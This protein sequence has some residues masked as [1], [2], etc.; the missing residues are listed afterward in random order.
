MTM[1]SRGTMMMLAVLVC[2]IS[3]TGVVRADISVL[4]TF[5]EES[6][7]GVSDASGNERD[8]SE[9][10]S[11]NDLTYGETGQF[12]NA[13]LFNGN[14]SNP[15]GKFLLMTPDDG[16]PGDGDEVTIVFWAKSANWATDNAV[17][18]NYNAN[19]LRFSVGLNSSAYGLVIGVANGS[20]SGGGSPPGSS[21]KAYVKLNGAGTSGV[22]LSAN[23][24]HHFALVFSD[25]T[26][27]AIYIDGEEVVEDGDSYWYFNDVDT[28]TVG[29]RSVSTYTPFVF[30]G[31]L[32]DFAI[33]NE[34]LDESA[35]ENIMANGVPTPLFV[36]YAFDEESGPGVLDSSGN[37]RDMSETSSGN[38]LTYG[39]T[40]QFEN[41]LRFNGNDGNPGGK[42]LL[43]TP[44]AGMPGDGDEVTIVFWA[45]SANWAGDNAIICNYNANGLRFSVGLN[46]TNYGLTVGVA[47]GSASG[48]GSPPGNSGKAY[49]KL[50]GAGTSGVNLSAN[51]W[52]HFAIAFSDNAISAI[53]IDGDEVAED[54]D[55]YWY[56][57]DV[58]NFTIGGRILGTSTPFVFNGLLDDF[59]IYSKVLS[60]SEI[61]DIMAGAGGSGGTGTTV[62]ND[63]FET[64]VL[65]WEDNF[66]TFDTNRW[67]TY[68]QGDS[69][70]SVADGK[71]C[72]TLNSKTGKSNARVQ[73]LLG[74][75]T[76]YDPSVH[77]EHKYGRVVC[78]M[79]TTTLPYIWSTFYAIHQDYQPGT[80]NVTAWTELDGGEYMGDNWELPQSILYWEGELGGELH[81]SVIWR[82]LWFDSNADYHEY[83]IEWTPEHL[84]Y[85]VDG[86]ITRRETPE[87]LPAVS[88]F[89][90]PL[91]IDMSQITRDENLASSNDYPNTAYY[92]YIAYYKL[93]STE[94]LAASYDSASGIQA[95]TNYIYSCDPGDYAYYEDVDLKQF[96]KVSLEVACQS[97][98]REVL[99]R[100]GSPTGTVIATIPVPNTG[101][102]TLY[103]TSVAQLGEVSGVQDLYLTFSGGGCGNI[104]NFRFFGGV[105]DPNHYPDWQDYRD[106]LSS[107]SGLLA[108]Y[109]FEA[110]SGNTLENIATAPSNPSYFDGSIYDSSSWT[111]GRW[112]DKGALYFDGTSDSVNCGND[113]R[114]NSSTLT[115]EAWV[116]FK[117][118]STQGQG[119][120]SKASTYKGFILQLDG[121]TLR[122]YFRDASSSSWK[123]AQSTYTIRN[124]WTHIVGM[125]KSNGDIELWVDGILRGTTSMGTWDTD[126]SDL[127]I[128]LVGTTGK[129]KGFIDEVAIYNREL[130]PAEIVAHCAAGAR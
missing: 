10:S 84:S 117:N 128:G 37:L 30:N 54:G 112:T 100:T 86:H 8:M 62:T 92:D 36:H 125:R 82:D 34:A 44:D 97:D 90:F 63:L 52:H 98:D 116:L 124:A 57:N 119:L 47:N 83:I 115:M 89:V 5:N 118:T 24:W 11:G 58:D 71:L 3:I 27:S 13:L 45:N 6:G 107:D 73:T 55:S 99:I 20:A 7:P 109:D 121:S 33:Y 77:K 19:G 74:N 96:R 85:Y 80:A 16:M 79:K 104:R 67:T 110:G 70:I 66:D 120:I 2:A 50:N 48:G 113:E 93:D 43:M 91:R 12:A 114:L 105:E 40:G 51:T 46:S 103:K 59:A 61:E 81:S 68:S 56:F 49:V 9:T 101:S 35:I 65:D 72:L 129:F 122:L 22:N 31:L 126:D 87:T 53:Y 39:E 26:I 15:G 95:S 111:A 4:Y 41:A 130:T 29:G 60:E 32:D 38:D 127:K 25:N 106:D 21:G 1:T 17:I 94:V 69:S 75:E 88:Q 108:Y 18:C 64:F 76:P 102:S 123:Y 14:D 42:F 23:T 28:F 78:R